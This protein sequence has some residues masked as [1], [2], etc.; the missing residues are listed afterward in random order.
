MREDPGQVRAGAMLRRLRMADP[1]TSSQLRNAPLPD[2]A[3]YGLAMPLAVVVL[4]A[5][6]FAVFKW[7]VIS[8][9]AF[10]Q[11]RLLATLPSE[12]LR[13]FIERAVAS[14][15][16]LPEAVSQGLAAVFTVGILLGFVV[17]APLA[18][19]WRVPPLFVLSCLG[20][21]AGAFLPLVA[22]PWLVSL[23]IGLAYGTA[24]AARGKSV[25]LV[26]AGT[27]RDPTLVSGL[28]N[29]GLAVGLLLGTAVGNGLAAACIGDL[30]LPPG[31]PGRMVGALVDADWIAH[32]VL[33]VLLAG[34]TACALAVRI[35]DERPTPFAAG[36]ADLVGG[37][38]RMLRRHGALL[39]SG[40]I[41]W[42]IISAL[43]ITAFVYCVNE[44]RIP[45]VAATI[46]MACAGAG[47]VVGN[48][49]SK[50]CATRAWVL[51]LYAVF[52]VG[53]AA[54]PYLAVGLWSAGALMC[55][56]GAAYMIPTNVIDAR[57]LHLAGQSGEAG[58]GGTVFSM[59]HNVC[60]LAIGTGMSVLLFAGVLTVHT[61]FLFLA[62]LAL[63]ALVVAAG[64]R[65]RD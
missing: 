57:F 14:G 29:A 51:G 50:H 5:M 27:G 21:A 38:A 63:A 42:G 36:L 1:H 25:P 19:A 12:W 31:D 17:N 46:L 40:G 13:L 58:R 52:A 23:G 59:V 34:T 45:Q 61:Q 24:C 20:M 48:L 8:E 22:N 7:V 3:R 18:G 54:F 33:V 4:T 56:I 2:P 60:I 37:T 6:C 39:L 47:A 9:I 16:A 43:A 53:I 64:A 35:P 32:A 15:I 65:L 26:A 41:A 11:E 62:V 10:D 44:L 30:S 55:G 28:V 49:V